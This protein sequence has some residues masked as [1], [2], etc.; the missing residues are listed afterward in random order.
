MPSAAQFFR[1]WPRKFVFRALA[2]KTVFL[3][4][5]PRSRRSLPFLAKPAEST[6]KSRFAAMSF[7]MSSGNRGY[8]TV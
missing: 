1:K 4:A 3:L 7:T 2:Q 6:E 5:G 8:R